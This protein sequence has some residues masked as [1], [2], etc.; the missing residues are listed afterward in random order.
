MSISIKDYCEVVSLFHHY[1][2]AYCFLLHYLVGLYC[3]QSAISKVIDINTC[4]TPWIYLT[5]AQQC[6]AYIEGEK[7]ISFRNFIWFIIISFQCIFALVIIF[8][9]GINTPAFSRFESSQSVHNSGIMV[10]FHQMIK[11]ASDWTEDMYIIFGFDSCICNKKALWGS[12]QICHLVFDSH[13]WVYYLQST[14]VIHSLF[15]ENPRVA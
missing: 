1:F 9:S 12:L 3:D 15:F 2:Q 11:I 6:F 4:S 8:K 10:E 14:I 7:L 5:W 13:P